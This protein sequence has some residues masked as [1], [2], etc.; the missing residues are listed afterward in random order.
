MLIA[1]CLVDTRDML[2]D[3][4]TK[5]II[6]R[7]Q[8]HACTHGPSIVAPELTLWKAKGKMTRIEL[9][10]AATAV[11]HPQGLLLSPF[12]FLTS[13]PARIT[14]LSLELLRVI[15]RLRMLLWKRERRIPGQT[16]GRSSA[17]SVLYKRQV[18]KGVFSPSEQCI[19][20][21]GTP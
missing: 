7:S 6:D 3:G 10:S 13:R 16:R 11:S 5:G 2:A 17:A 8:V 1:I 4:A 19:L 20:Y 15:R 9:A 12:S 18:L 21:Y 14:L